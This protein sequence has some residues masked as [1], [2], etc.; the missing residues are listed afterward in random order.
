MVWV[1][2]KKII[3]VHIPKTG[4]TSIE[5]AMNAMD[6]AN[7]YGVIKNVAQQHFLWNVYCEKLGVNRF[8]AYFKFAVCRNPYDKLISEYFWHPKIGFKKNQSIDDF[9]NYTEEVVNKEIFEESIYHDHFIPQH[10]YVY[11]DQDKLRVDKLFYFEKF[12]EIESFLAERFN[13]K[14]KGKENV[15]K[16]KKYN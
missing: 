12:Q 9:I 11:D 10:K 8:N 4:G 3:F 14:I 13:I 16:K 15:G 5:T 6:L 7:G 2:D 1:R